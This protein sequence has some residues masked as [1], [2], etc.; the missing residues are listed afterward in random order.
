MSWTGQSAEASS[1]I[2]AATK[3]RRWK[4]VATG[5][6]AGTTRGPMIRTAHH[7]RT[8]IEATSNQT[9]GW[10]CHCHGSVAATMVTTGRN[11]ATTTTPTNWSPP[12]GDESH[13]PLCQNS[14]TVRAMP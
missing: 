12:P 5:C 11:P 4:G 9:S 3:A 1:R 10:A 8:R 7:P 14:K 6:P 2:V 13:Q